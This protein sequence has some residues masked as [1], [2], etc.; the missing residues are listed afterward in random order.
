MMTFVNAHP[1]L[2][3]GM[4]VS[5]VWVHNKDRGNSSKKK[6]SGSCVQMAC[7]EAFL[8]S[9]ETD[10]WKE[11]VPKPKCVLLSPIGIFDRMI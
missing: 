6:G 2:L 7:T 9:V 1:T 11:Q 8:P 4:R 3:L 5:G 10:R